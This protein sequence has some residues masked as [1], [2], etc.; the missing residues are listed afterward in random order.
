MIGNLSARIKSSIWW[1]SRSKRQNDKSYVR[2]VVPEAGGRFNKKISS[3]QYRKS[4]FG[5]KTIFRPSY[6]HNGISYTGKMTSFY[7]IRALVSRAWISNYMTQNSMG[8]NYL[9]MPQT[10]VFGSK[11]II[12][13]PMTWYT[14]AW[15]CVS[16]EYFI[17]H[18]RITANED[19]EFPVKRYIYFHMF[20]TTMIAVCDFTD[21]WYAFCK[22][23][24]FCIFIKI[25]LNT[26]K[27][28]PGGS[29]D[30]KSSSV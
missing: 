30:N 19:C 17:I 15:S 3:Y 6:L 22:I 18:T 2:T 28:I 20:R 25:S 5:D 10:P 21:I 23:S 16:I 13:W 14:L 12:Y 24:F 11:V 27:F 1:R 29:I 26:F 4:H 7:W 8:C 9:S